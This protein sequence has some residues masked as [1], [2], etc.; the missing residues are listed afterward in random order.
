MPVDVR[1]PDITAWK[2]ALA[3]IDTTIC[4]DKSDGFSHP[5]TT[6]RLILTHITSPSLTAVLFCL[7]HIIFMEFPTVKHLACI[8]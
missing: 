7:Q 8:C 3:V 6:F 4:A 5:Y 2:G 1:H